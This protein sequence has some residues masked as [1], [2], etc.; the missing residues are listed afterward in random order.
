ML[1]TRREMPQ[2]MSRSA[3]ARM[4]IAIPMVAVSLLVF[5]TG[6]RNLLVT[7]TDGGLGCRTCTGTSSCVGP[8]TCLGVCL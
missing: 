7:C 8:S 3:L 1:G 5:E 6:C 2:A 4:G